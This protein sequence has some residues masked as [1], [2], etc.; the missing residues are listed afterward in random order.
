MAAVL[1]GLGAG[2]FVLIVS[3]LPGVFARFNVDV[4]F[5]SHSDTVMVQPKTDDRRIGD[6]KVVRT[7][8]STIILFKKVELYYAFN[9]SSLYTII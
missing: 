9:T 2:Y 7:Y 5:Q 3:S 1:A 8:N 4:V 6:G